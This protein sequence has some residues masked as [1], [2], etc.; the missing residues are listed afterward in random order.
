MN[1][2]WAKRIDIILEAGGD[3]VLHDAGK[4]VEQR[5]ASH[6]SRTFLLNYRDFLGSCLLVQFIC[7]ITEIHDITSHGVCWSVC[8]FVIEIIQ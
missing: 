6:L 3:A 7:V 2:D 4:V 1:E 5:V 8:F